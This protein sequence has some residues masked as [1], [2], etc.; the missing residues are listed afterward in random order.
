[1]GADI[2]HQFCFESSN[3]R[4][5]ALTHD[6]LP[7]LNRGLRQMNAFSRLLCVRAEEPPV[8]RS[9]LPDALDTAWYNCRKGTIK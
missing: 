2:Q 4:L 9:H 7:V 8:V 6:L 1:M 5:V 3:G